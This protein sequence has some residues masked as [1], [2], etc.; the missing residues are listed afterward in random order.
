MSSGLKANCRASGDSSSSLAT[1]ASALFLLL[2]WPG[3]LRAQLWVGGLAGVGHGILY[4]TLTALL[5]DQVESGR[6]GRVLG[7]F[8][9]AIVLGA[10]LGP[11][12]MGVVAQRIGYPGMF[13]LTGLLPLLGVLLIG[14][15]L[16]RSYWKP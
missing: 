3:P 1:S 13:G 14:I 8:S 16:R 4:P 2:L 11:M 5:V 10:S 7:L 6:R 15:S 12:A 9:S